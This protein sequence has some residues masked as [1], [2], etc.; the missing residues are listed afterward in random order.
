MINV[1]DSFRAGIELQADAQL[2]PSLRLMANLTLSQNKIKNLTEFVDNWDTGE[3]ESIFYKETDIS[4]S[5]PVIGGLNI[6]YMPLQNLSLM[7]QAKYVG[8]QYI[9][10]SSSD[11]RKIDPYYVSDLRI[12]YSLSLPYIRHLNF[13]FVL[14]N[15]FDHQYESN[16]WVYSY[17]Y[18][19]QRRKMDGYF[20]QAGIH[21]ITGLEIT[22]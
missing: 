7:L 9:D 20:P 5:P 2:M 18:E 10:N 14:N 13:F 6:Q 3:Q 8:K 12:D 4:F 15:I 16:A 19:N 17:I 21:F 22:L 1:P 11:E